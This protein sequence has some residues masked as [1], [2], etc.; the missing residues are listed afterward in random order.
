MSKEKLFHVGVKALIEN[1]E[2]KILLL[3]APGWEKAKT[4]AH[5]DIPG[6]RIQEGQT[7]EAALSREIEEET[8]VKKIEYSEFFTA[9][10]SNHQIPHKDIMLGLVLMVYRVKIP[11]SSKIKL[12]EEHTDYEWVDKKE[13][14]KRLAYKYPSEFTN[15]L[16]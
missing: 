1:E 2:G 4:K 6:G 7:I 13:A 8:G 5:W 9:I 14:T 10:I 16:K 15:L 12:S 11:K 3:K